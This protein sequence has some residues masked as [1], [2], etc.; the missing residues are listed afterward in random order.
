MQ[1]V[2]Q[3][4]RTRSDT[5]GESPGRRENRR[6]IERRGGGATRQRSWGSPKE[7]LGSPKA[8]IESNQPIESTD[9]SKDVLTV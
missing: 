9:L 6:E 2:G 1:V 7:V 8:G 4:D 5:A 3:G